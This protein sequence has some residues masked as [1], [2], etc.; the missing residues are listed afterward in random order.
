[1]VVEEGAAGVAVVRYTLTLASE[2]AGG[3]VTVDI[4]IARQQPGSGGGGDGEAAD[5][6]VAAFPASA[7]FDSTNW[8]ATLAVDLRYVVAARGGAVAEYG[9]VAHRLEHLVR[10]SVD[11]QYSTRGKSILPI[12]LLANRAKPAVVTSP[13]EGGLTQEEVAM[14]ATGL[15]L[16]AAFAVLV[17]ARIHRSS[18]AKIRQAQSKVSVAHEETRESAQ[19]V[20]RVEREKQA[21]QGKLNSA[22]MLVKQ[23]MAEGG[24]LLD[25]YHLEY[26]DIAFEGGAAEEDRRKL[27]EGAQ[28]C[29]R[30]CALRCAASYCSVLAHPPSLTHD[31]N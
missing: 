5:A 19:R 13:V 3:E 7:T 4:R 23:V 16:S 17:V 11:E 10:S 12:E 22:Q 27:G 15:V 25:S 14:L 26:S 6:L 29:A 8:N 24:A 18:T 30:R 31:R 21:L 1:M 9:T 20:E 28:V 2:P